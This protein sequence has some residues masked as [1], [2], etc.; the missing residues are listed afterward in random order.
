MCQL[1]ASG[2]K[3][4][5]VEAKLP[6]NQGDADLPMITPI[7]ARLTSPPAPSNPSSR[8]HAPACCT[9]PPSTNNSSNCGAHPALFLFDFLRQFAKLFGLLVARL[10]LQ[11][12]ELPGVLSRQDRHQSLQFCRYFACVI[13]L[14]QH[15]M[16]KITDCPV[17]IHRPRFGVH[18]GCVF[19]FSETNFSTN[20]E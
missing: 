7:S 8:S 3:G 17:V 2:G 19:Y 11:L 15:Q 9:G 1:R 13:G 20:S 5:G 12:C 4:S 6:D 18:S 16:F 14:F 10:Y